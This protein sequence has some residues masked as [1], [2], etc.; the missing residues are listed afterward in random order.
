MSISIP[1]LPKK[2]SKE[3]TLVLDLDE[4]L[5]FFSEEN[6][7]K[8]VFIRPFARKLINIL[9]RYFELVIFTAS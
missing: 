4:T 7:N 9:K 2:H 6:K 1:F 3:F 5:V 8:S